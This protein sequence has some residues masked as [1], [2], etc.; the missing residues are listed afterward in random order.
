MRITFFEVSS[1]VVILLV[2]LWKGVKNIP[3]EA[4]NGC[5]SSQ[6]SV[7]AVHNNNVCSTCGYVAATQRLC[8]HGKK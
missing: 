2:T 8:V 4:L 1:C 5:N 7:L 3:V 6:Q